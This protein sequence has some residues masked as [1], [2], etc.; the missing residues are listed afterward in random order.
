M[1]QATAPIKHADRFFIGGQ[2]VSPSSDAKISVFDSDTEQ[3]YFAVAEAQAP[4]IDRAVTAAREA[5]DS[6][7]GRG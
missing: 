1:T 3:L 4:D 6:G 5:F 2:W 7:P